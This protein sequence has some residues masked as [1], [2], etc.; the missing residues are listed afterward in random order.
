V[1]LATWHFSSIYLCGASDALIAVLLALNERYDSASKRP[2][3][4]F[5]NLAIAPSRFPER[6]QRLLEGP[7]DSNGRAKAVIALAALVDDVAAIVST[8]SA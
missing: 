6:F 5:K 4:D 2:E 1:E 7:F 8:G 3:N